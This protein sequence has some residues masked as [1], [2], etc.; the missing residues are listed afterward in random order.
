MARMAGLVLAGG[1]F[2]VAVPSS[3]EASNDVVLALVSGQTHPAERVQE[4]TWHVVTQNAWPDKISLEVEWFLKGKKIGDKKTPYMCS[5]ASISSEDPSFKQ[6]GAPVSV[7]S[8][9][10]SLADMADRRYRF[11]ASGVKTNKS[12]VKTEVYTARMTCYYRKANQEKVTKTIETRIHVDA[13][14]TAFFDP[15]LT[16]NQFCVEFVRPRDGDRVPL[17]EGSKLSLKR[18]AKPSTL[19]EVFINLERA[20]KVYSGVK[21]DLSLPEGKVYGSEWTSVYEGAYALPE[22][23]KTLHLR[24]PLGGG[25][26]GGLYR[27]RV[28]CFYGQGLNLGFTPMSP[29]IQYWVGTEIATMRPL[30][31]QPA[32]GLGTQPGKQTAEAD[33][34]ALKVTAPKL[35][36]SR[37][38]VHPAPLKAGAPVNLEISFENK[39]T[40]ASAP[41]AQYKLTCA[42]VQGG[43]ECPAPS[44]DR[45][46]GKSIEPGQTG[47]VILLGAKPAIAGEYRVSVAVP[48]DQPGRPFSITLKVAPVVTGPKVQPP[49]QRPQAPSQ[50][51]SAPS[52]Q[53]G[54]KPR[55][56]MVPR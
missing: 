16:E 5:A 2:L 35:G 42:V 24:L 10:H 34:K 17:D 32:G 29:W 55:L 48:P 33:P 51:Q 14:A 50:P 39:G 20:A 11:T 56:R 28:H 19:R 44:G 27:A 37:I 43:P 1:A 25:M 7:P 54:E 31:G 3:A 26:Q 49:D 4:H 41:D 38:A 13:N 46:I 12:I 45:T 47:S 40:K 15:G 52:S 53:E 6:E 18:S 9:G 23:G 8:G 36:V 21:G 30:S 22:A